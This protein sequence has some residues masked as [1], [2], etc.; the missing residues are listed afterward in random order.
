MKHYSIGF[1]K[2]VSIE[3]C[4]DGVLSYRTHPKQQRRHGN[5]LPCYSVSSA[6]TAEL[7]LTTIAKRTYDGEFLIHDFDGTLE[8]IERVS[9]LLYRTELRINK[10]NTDG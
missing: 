8:G 1:E 2:K 7:L 4:K 3:I 5:A 6:D 9:E 10:G